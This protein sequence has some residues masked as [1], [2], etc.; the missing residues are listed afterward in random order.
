MGNG[1][2]VNSLKSIGRRRN[3]LDVG[4]GAN[5]LK[6]EVHVE[7]KKD[8]GVLHHHQLQC[9]PQTC[10]VSEPILPSSSGLSNIFTS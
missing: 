8:T 2:S 1:I 3:R 9:E 7:R 6:E 5:A 10:S 4:T